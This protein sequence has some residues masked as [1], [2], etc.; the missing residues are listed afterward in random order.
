MDVGNG[1][2]APHRDRSEARAM[3]DLTTTGLKGEALRA[4]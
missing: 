3:A 2:A 1:V 4:R